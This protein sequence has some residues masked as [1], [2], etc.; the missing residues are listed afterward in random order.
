VSRITKPAPHGHHR[1]AHLADAYQL[2][3]RCGEILSTG[4][5]VHVV[6]RGDRGTWRG[7][8]YPSGLDWWGIYTHSEGPDCPPRAVSGWQA[9]RRAI[10]MQGPDNPTTAEVEAL[11]KRK[12]GEGQPVILWGF[13]FPFVSLL[14]CEHCDV[15][16]RAVTI[17]RRETLESDRSPV[18]SVSDGREP[19][20]EGDV[21][22]YKYN[23]RKAGNRY[24]YV[25]DAYIRA[26]D[27]R[28][29]VLGKRAELIRDVTAREQTN[30]HVRAC[31]VRGTMDCV[32][33]FYPPGDVTKKRPDY[34]IRAREESKKPIL[35]GVTH[36]Q[37][38]TSDTAGR[39]VEYA[40][41][42]QVPVTHGERGD[43]KFWLEGKTLDELH[44]YLFSGPKPRPLL[45]EF[46]TRRFPELFEWFDA[47]S[48]LVEH[49]PRNP[50]SPRAGRPARL[51]QSALRKI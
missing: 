17:G 14:D 43:N 1:L 47:P 18:Q 5:T 24:D 11:G 51:K 15:E 35:K 25:E 44:F 26:L 16:K 39:P 7:Y 41:Y 29:T 30:L 34:E 21:G 45:F 37:V 49:W 23:V 27:A 48:D 9:V 6:Y 13:V 40:L 32:F 19:D 8:I 12:G 20:K 3:A 38:L 10:E 46:D 50:S 33:E 22:G 2:C 28:E 31:A 42:S 36:G 4:E